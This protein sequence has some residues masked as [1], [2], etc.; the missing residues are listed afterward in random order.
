GAAVVD[1]RTYAR[2]EEPQIGFTGVTPHFFRTLGLALIKGRDVTD[3]EG[4]SRTPV[5]AVNQ[6]MAA[7]LWPEADAVG[8]RFRLADTQPFEWFTVIGVAPDIR[9]FDL[10]DDTPPFPVAFVPYPYGA[11]ANTGLMIRVTTNPRGIISAARE[12]IR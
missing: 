6:T 5:A 7:R 4:M 12:A 9:Q 8:Q 3:A 11:T 1:G 10:D 2:G